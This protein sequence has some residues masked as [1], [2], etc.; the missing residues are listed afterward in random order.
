MLGVYESLTLVDSTLNKR[1]LNKSKTISK[2]AHHKK[3]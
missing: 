1:I 3:N 2:I